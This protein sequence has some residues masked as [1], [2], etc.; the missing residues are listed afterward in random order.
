MHVRGNSVSLLINGNQINVARDDGLA[1]RPGAVGI[2]FALTGQ[3]ADGQ[4][5]IR[6]TGFKVYALP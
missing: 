1:A 2:H 4:V 3:P 6:F 5:E